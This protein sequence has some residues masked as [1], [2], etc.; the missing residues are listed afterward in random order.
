MIDLLEDHWVLYDWSESLAPHHER[1]ACWLEELALVLYHMPYYK[2]SVKLDLMTIEI[3][4]TTTDMAS[5]AMLLTL[6]IFQALLQRYQYYSKGYIF[7][8][9]PKH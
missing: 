4:L 9:S 3:T 7:G 5:V 6:R 1:K 8:S 2:L